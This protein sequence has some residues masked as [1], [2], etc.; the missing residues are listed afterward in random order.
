MTSLRRLSGPGRQ[1]WMLMSVT[2]VTLRVI[3]HH[4]QQDIQRATL[5]FFS[6]SYL[7]QSAVHIWA[8]VVIYTVGLYY[9]VFPS[10]VQGSSPQIGLHSI[11]TLFYHIFYYKD[12]IQILLKSHVMKLTF[13]PYIK[14][15]P[16]FV[17]SITLPHIYSQVLHKKQDHPV[18]LYLLQKES[19]NVI[20]CLI[21]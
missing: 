7:I 2:M 13:L 14:F 18:S 9:L 19:R 4:H 1:P 8:C 16:C 12:I 15:S 20:P 10:S 5:F 17:K 3:C 6:F 11:N 21:L